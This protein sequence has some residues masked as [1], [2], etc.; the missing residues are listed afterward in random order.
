MRSLRQKKESV[1]DMLRQRGYNIIQMLEHD[2]VHRKKTE[3]FKEFL[4]QHEVTDRLNPRDTFFGG[5]TNGIKLFFEGCAKYIDFTSLYPWVNKYCQY[6]VGHPEIITEDFRDIDRYF[7]LVKCKGFPPKIYSTPCYHFDAMVNRCFLSVARVLKPSIKTFTD[8]FTPYGYTDEE[9]YISGTWVTE[10]LDSAFRIIERCRRPNKKFNSEEVIFQ[11]LLDPD[12]WLN[13]GA[14]TIGQTNDA[15]RTLFETL[16]RRV[17]SSLSLGALEKKAI[18]F[19]EHLDRPIST[20][21]KC[22]YR[23]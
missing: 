6:P 11:V 10:E 5:R 19:W 2:F 13:N 23:K 12:C 9:R 20:L 14:T 8:T 4:L 7:G 18:I 21:L 1:I 16:L 15:I 3:Q 17:T 22:L